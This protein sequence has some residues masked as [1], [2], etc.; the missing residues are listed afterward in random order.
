MGRRIYPKVLAAA[1]GRAISKFGGSVITYWLLFLY[2]VLALLLP[3]R[4][5]AEMRRFAWLFML[6]IFW[7]F[8]GF[9]DGIGGDWANYLSHYER[10]A[11]SSLLESLSHRSVG[12]GLINW[13]FSHLSIGIYG[14]NAFCAAL[15]V[16]GLDRFCW[17]QP[18]PWLAWLVLTPYLIFVVGT[19]YT[20]QSVA[21]AFILWGFS[22]LASRKIGRFALLTLIAA[23]FHKSA[24]VSLVFLGPLILSKDSRDKLWLWLRGKSLTRQKKSLLAVLGLTTVL[25][26]IVSVPGIIQSF[27]NYIKQDYYRS[28]GAFIRTAMTAVP[29]IVWIALFLGSP[30]KRLFSTVWVWIAASAILMVPGSLIFP[31]VADRLA[32]YLIGVQPYVYCRLPLFFKA[33]AGRG[34]ILSGIIL[35]H[36]MVI[37]IWFSFAEHAHFWKPYSNLFLR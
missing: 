28:E 18:S 26:V 7:I 3:V 36:A 31:T 29:A 9:R 1:K 14:V 16:F 24:L 4:A 32:L 10:L 8:I 33:Q 6:F 11:D 30:E 19:G 25:V 23:I 22:E 37:W 15:F 34:A 12:Y 27:E 20:V 2:P 17:K 35:I 5:T 13:S 21:I